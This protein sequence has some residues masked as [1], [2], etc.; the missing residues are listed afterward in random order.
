MSV[1]SYLDNGKYL[2]IAQ[3]LGLIFGLLSQLLLTRNLDISNYGV[4]I[5]LIDFSFT[6]AIIIDFGIPTWASRKWDGKSE[7]V[8]NLINK[9]MS[10]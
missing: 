7:S 8:R 2:A 5:L 9:I 4:F 3:G 6:M 10:I 1:R